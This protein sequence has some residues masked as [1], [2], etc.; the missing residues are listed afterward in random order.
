MFSADPA[1][2]AAAMARGADGFADKMRPTQDLIDL[3]WPAGAPT[4]AEGG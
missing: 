2:A 1:I 4:D 3:L